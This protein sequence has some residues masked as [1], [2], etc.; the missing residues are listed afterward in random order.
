MEYEKIIARIPTTRVE[1]DGS[2]KRCKDMYVN[3]VDIFKEELVE[4]D[5]RQITSYMQQLD[6]DCKETEEDHVEYRGNDDEKSEETEA[7]SNGLNTTTKET[8][9]VGDG[10]EKEWYSRE[11]KEQADGRGLHGVGCHTLVMVN[12][13]GMP[14]LFTLNPGNFFAFCCMDIFDTRVPHF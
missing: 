4:R 10:W 2:Y 14:L 7:E 1:L 9:D 13:L 11:H 6:V 12:H 5:I 8:Q 3:D